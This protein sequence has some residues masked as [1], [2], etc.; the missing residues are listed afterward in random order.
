M[1]RATYCVRMKICELDLKAVM[2]AVREVSKF[3]YSKADF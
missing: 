1:S 2:V 3:F